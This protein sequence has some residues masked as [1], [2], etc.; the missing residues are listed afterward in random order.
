MRNAQKAFGR[1][2]YFHGGMRA[3]SFGRLFRNLLHPEIEDGLS[4]NVFQTRVLMKGIITGG[5][6][7]KPQVLQHELKHASRML[8]VAAHTIQAAGQRR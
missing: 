3:Q 4:Q 7:P 5:G 6:E 2:T 1:Y 8:Q